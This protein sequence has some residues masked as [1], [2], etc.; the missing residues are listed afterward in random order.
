MRATP[1]RTWCCL[2]TRLDSQCGPSRRQITGHGLPGAGRLAHAPCPCPLR[3][4]LRPGG[5][6]MQ[7][8]GSVFRPAAARTG[9]RTLALMRCQVPSWRPWAKGWQTVDWDGRS[10]GIMSQGGHRRA[11]APVTPGSPAH[12]R[13]SPYRACCPGPW[14]THPPTP[15]SL[16]RAACLRDG[17]ALP[18]FGR[19]LG[20]WPN[21][22][23][24]R[25]GSGPRPAH[26]P[27]LRLAT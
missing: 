17:G 16:A 15:L 25:P 14:A 22:P 20:P 2:G 8:A 13:P 1:G 7:A 18:V 6:R 24:L 26:H 12:S 23:H 21:P 4:L 9:G 11:A 19:K 10:W 3:L 5:P 27:R